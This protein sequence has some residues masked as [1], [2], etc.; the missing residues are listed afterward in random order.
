MN[1][2]FLTKGFDQCGRIR[3][4]D[5]VFIT[6]IIFPTIQKKRGC[7]NRTQNRM[8]TILSLTTELEELLK[9]K[10]QLQKISQSIEEEEKYL[11]KRLRILEEKIE[12]QVLREKIGAKRAAVEQLKS[13]IWNLEKRLKEPQ[14]KPE[15][16]PMPQRLTPTQTSRATEKAEEPRKKE[17]IEVTVSAAPAGAQ[18]PRRSEERQEQ[19]KKKESRF[20]R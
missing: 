13:K 16:S 14:K 19:Q 15:P 4:I 2:D 10:T 17:P 8:R 20:F 11:A 18:Q 12:I 6:L 5:S 3:N 7:Q 1:K 9:E